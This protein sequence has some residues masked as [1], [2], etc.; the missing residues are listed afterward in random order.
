MFGG[1]VVE[2]DA[3]VQPLEFVRRVDRCVDRMEGDVEEPG[4]SVAGCF[5]NSALANPPLGLRR[6]QLRGVALLV[7]ADAVAVPGVFVGARTVLVG[8]GIGR[9]GERAVAAVSYT[10]STLPTTREVVI[11]VGRRKSQN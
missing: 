6:D 10:P 3:V 11:S 9:A 2:A 1:V 7:E 8:P 5:R 4:L